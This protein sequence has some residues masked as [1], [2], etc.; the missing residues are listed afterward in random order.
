MIRLLLLFIAILVVWMLFKML[1]R[2][3]TLEEARTIGLQ[4]ASAHINNPILLEDYID[5]RG[6]PREA[7]DP[8]IEAG[9]IP[10]YHWQQY[11]YIENRELIVDKK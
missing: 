9:D 1:T 7:L 5:S 11:K 6:I 4:E 10:S 2:K 3:A 8:L